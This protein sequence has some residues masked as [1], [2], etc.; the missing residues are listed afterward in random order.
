ME[1]HAAT[2]VFADIFLI[3]IVSCHRMNFF[4]MI[5]IYVYICEFVRGSML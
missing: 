5:V 2:A 1:T 4:I 3:D